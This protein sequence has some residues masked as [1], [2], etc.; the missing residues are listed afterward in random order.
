MVRISLLGQSGLL[1]LGA[2]ASQRGQLRSQCPC[3][4][5]VVLEPWKAV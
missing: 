4:A 2:T 3:P 5:W 1:L